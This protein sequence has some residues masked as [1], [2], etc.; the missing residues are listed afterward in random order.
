MKILENT[1]EMFYLCKQNLLCY[2]IK[3]AGCN[4]RIVLLDDD[5]MQCL[6]E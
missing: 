6:E 4:Y 2:N 1:I 5:A 3:S